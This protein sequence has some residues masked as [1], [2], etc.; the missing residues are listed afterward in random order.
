LYFL[1][2][3]YRLNCAIFLLKNPFGYFQDNLAQMAENG[4]T[5][6]K[7]LRHFNHLTVNTFNNRHFFPS[8]RQ[9]FHTWENGGLLFLVRLPNFLSLFMP[10][11]KLFHGKNFLFDQLIV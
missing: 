2:G 4:L 1:H 9:L 10:T 6:V 7:F 3:K 8:L 11:L 5:I